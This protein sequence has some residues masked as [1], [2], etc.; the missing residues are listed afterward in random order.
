MTVSPSAHARTVASPVYHASTAQ[1]TTQSPAT[2]RHSAPCARVG[3]AA[4]RSS[5]NTW[6]RSATS[7][8][9]ANMAM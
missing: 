9:E 8:G 2:P 1:M 6:P 3:T 5:M 4:A 7:H